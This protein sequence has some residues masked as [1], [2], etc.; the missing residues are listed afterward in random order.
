[1]NDIE[2]IIKEMENSSLEMEKAIDSLMAT[3][4]QNNELNY[5]IRYRVDFK[6]LCERARQSEIIAR[7]QYKIDNLSNLI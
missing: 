5:N 4:R 2:A 1:M 6:M 3:I 7:V